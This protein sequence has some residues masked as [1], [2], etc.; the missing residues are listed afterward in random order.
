MFTPATRRLALIVFSLTTA[1]LAC[2]RA[3]L[4][5]T[6]AVPRVSTPLPAPPSATSAPGTEIALVTPGAT[7]TASD[8]PA[9][10]TEAAALPASPTSGAQ[11]TATETPPPPTETAISNPGV[12]PD[13]ATFLQTFTVSNE[14]GTLVG[15]GQDMADGDTITWVSLRGGNAAWILDLGSPQNVAGLLLYPHRDGNE[16]TTLLGIDV[17][18]DGASWTQVHV[19]LG[20]CG[21]VPDCD[22]LTQDEYLDL[23]FGPVRAQ[24]IRLR[25]GPTR[26]AFA[27]AQVAVVP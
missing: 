25:G 19:G 8:Y 10:A 11:A 17:S 27:E 24:Y 15:R 6:P 3:D 7:S 26:F 20:E 4:P 1:A 16:D 13:D 18:N 21:S 9:P 14:G 22:V 5:I 12:I 2:A 23:P